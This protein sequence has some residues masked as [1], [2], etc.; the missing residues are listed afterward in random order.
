MDLLSSSLETNL[1]KTFYGLYIVRIHIQ[2]RRGQSFDGIQISLKIGHQTF[3]K[4]FWFLVFQ[5]F[6]S[7]SKVLCTSIRDVIAIHA[8]QDDI[9]YAPLR[10]CLGSLDSCFTRCKEVNTKPL[11]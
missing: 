2:S 11:G 5:K 10:D 9:V 6:H 8:R 3:Y 1:L 7:M 4:Q